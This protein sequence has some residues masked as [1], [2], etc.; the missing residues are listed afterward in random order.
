MRNVLFAGAAA[1]VVYVVVN[2]AIVLL[3]QPSDLAVAAGYFLLLAL[4]ALAAGVASRL[5]RRL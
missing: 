1:A 5:W 4:V 2:R 3:N